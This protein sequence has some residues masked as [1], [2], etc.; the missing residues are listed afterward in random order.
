MGK[1]DKIHKEIRNAILNNEL[2]PGIPLS[3]N[4]IAKKY[5]VSRSPVREAIRILEKEQLV[6]IVQGR[7]TFV[8][9]LDRSDVSFLYEIRLSLEPLAARTSLNF[10]RDSE[11]DE[12]EDRWV[13]IREHKSDHNVVFWDTVF[14]LNRDTHRC[15]THKTPNPWLRNFLSIIDVHVVRMQKLSIESLGRIDETVEQHIEIIRL[16]KTR[17]IDRYVECLHDHIKNSEKYLLQSIDI[18]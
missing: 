5:N 13:A 7:G 4:E 8:S 3:E 9:T 10:I 17:D 12:L 14:G 2:K 6:K 15:F 1:T 11:L 16:A 18:E